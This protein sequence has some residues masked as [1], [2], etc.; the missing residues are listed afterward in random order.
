MFRCLPN[1]LLRRSL[2]TRS[3][4]PSA[5][6]H[7]FYRRCLRSIRSLSDVNPKIVGD[8]ASLMGYYTDWMHQHVYADGMQSFGDP[9]L[10]LRFLIE[11]ERKRMWVLEKYGIADS[12][13]SVLDTWEKLANLHQVDAVNDDESIDEDEDDFFK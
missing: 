4:I 6:F 11:G 5:T 3:A 10:S 1:Q 7:V 12:E 2:T 13:V 9:I 8:V